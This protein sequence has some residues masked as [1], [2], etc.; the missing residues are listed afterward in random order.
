[1]KSAS[2]PLLWSHFLVKKLRREDERKPAD[3]HLGLHHHIPFQSHYV[4]TAAQQPSL[5][6]KKGVTSNLQM[7]TVRVRKLSDSS[8][9]AQ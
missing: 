9:V 5:F 3:K 8:K 6:G 2:S 7:S 1:M 4:M